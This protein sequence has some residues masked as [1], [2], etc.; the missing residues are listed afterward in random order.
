MPR[1][2]VS[3]WLVIAVVGSGTSSWRPI[4]KASSISFCIM[5]TSNH[6]SS[7]IFKTNGPRY[8]TMGDAITL[9]SRTSTAVSRGMPLFSASSTP[10]LKASI[11]TARL[12]LVAIFIE[13]A[14]PLPPT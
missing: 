9:F 14:K 3:I 2:A 7:G 4:S 6:A 1:A 10:S 8:L 11:C 5:L 13:T 12:K